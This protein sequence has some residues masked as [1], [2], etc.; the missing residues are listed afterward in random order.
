MAFDPTLLNLYPAESGVYVMKNAEGRVLYIGK[1]N[2]LRQR[3]KQY[4][5]QQDERPMVSVLV[6]QIDA[7]ET[8][9]TLTEKDALILEN[10][11]IKQHRP[12]YNI[13]LKDDKTFISLMITQHHWPMFRLVRVKGKPEAPGMYFGPYTSAFAARKLFD[14][15]TRRFPL[16]QCSDGELLSRKRPCLLYDIK[17][18][19][20]PCVNKCTKKEYDHQVAAAIQFIKNQDGQKLFT[21][22]CDVLGL[23]RQADALVLALLQFRDGRLVA[24]DHFTFHQILNSDEE[25]VSSFLLQHYRVLPSA[26]SEILISIA[27]PDKELLQEI[28]SESHGRPIQ[29]SIPHKGKKRELIEMAEQ[30]AKAQFERHEDRRSLHEKMLLDLQEG[31]QLTRFPRRIEC[32]DTSH[33][34]GTHPVAAL[35]SFFHGER[36]KNRTRFFRIKSQERAEDLSAMREALLRHFSRQTREREFCDL[37]IVDG[38]RTQLGI[39]LEVFQELKIASV[40]LIALTKEQGR[41]DRGLTEE[42]IYVPHRSEPITLH[43]RSPSLFLL[44]RIRD[45]THR[46]AITYHRKRTRM[47]L[48]QSALDTIPGIG[49]IKKRALLKRFGSVRALKAAPKEALLDIPELTQRDIERV[50][51]FILTSNTI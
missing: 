9:I 28:L 17:R 3:L 48:T 21:E 20:A 19:I 31:L 43:P 36:E 13:L 40:D 11:L 18:C 29:L 1:A 42:K 38:G 45:E 32:I 24:A 27:L 22:S 6:P 37:L 5:A 8:M 23:F 50:W 51:E 7:I 47:T 26:P 25:V 16:R 2:N 10:Q 35:S 33:L 30:N 39:A 12:K 4:F 49:P 14:Q 44:Q 15:L 34:G 41:H 46:L